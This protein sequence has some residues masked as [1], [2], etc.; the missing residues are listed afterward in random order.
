M[1]HAVGVHAR[2]G[3]CVE[4]CL[5]PGLSVDNKSVAVML[6]GERVLE[7]ISYYYIISLTTPP[8]IENLAR[9]ECAVY[10]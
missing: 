7:V 3:S 5:G 1:M 10:V 6:A 4:C 8:R 2:T 9:R